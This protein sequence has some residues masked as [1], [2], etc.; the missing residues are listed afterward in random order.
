[1]DEELHLN[2]QLQLYVLW[3]IIFK[4]FKFDGEGLV[5]MGKPMDEWMTCPLEWKKIVHPSFM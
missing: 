5:I 2:D 3:Y 4:V 1:V